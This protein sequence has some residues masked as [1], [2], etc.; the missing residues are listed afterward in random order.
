VAGAPQLG[1]PSLRR[2]C[3]V[4]V[5]CGLA[6]VPTGVSRSQIFS[7]QTGALRSSGRYRWQ[8]DERSHIIS[9]GPSC[10]A[11][12]KDI[13]AALQWI[14]HFK[15]SLIDLAAAEARAYGGAVVFLFEH[16]LRPTKCRGPK[17]QLSR[18]SFR[19]TVR[20]CGLTKKTEP[21]ETRGAAI[22]T[23]GDT[24]TSAYISRPNPHQPRR[25]ASARTVSYQSILHHAPRASCTSSTGRYRR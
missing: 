8:C 23:Q 3:C 6:V 24:G 20:G 2:T 4:V 16:A 19:G 10:S 25:K 7:R 14:S 17:S 21:M 11:Y 9:R 12:A 5:A 15:I 18:T 1:A 22:K 13:L